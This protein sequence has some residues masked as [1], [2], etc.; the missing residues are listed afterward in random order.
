MYCEYA[1]QLI[2]MEHEGEAE[3]FAKKVIPGLDLLGATRLGV[4]SVW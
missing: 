1:T 4:A 2:L 3:T